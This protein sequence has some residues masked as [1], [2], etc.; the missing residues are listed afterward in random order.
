VRN[1]PNVRVE[2]FV[3]GDEKVIAQF[4]WN[5]WEGPRSARVD[6][7]KILKE[8]QLIKKRFLY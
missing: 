2:V 7:M 6:R 1:L 4:V 5:L 8:V 3:G